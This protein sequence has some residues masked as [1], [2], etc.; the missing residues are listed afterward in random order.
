MLFR[1]AGAGEPNDVGKSDA[2]QYQ[3]SAGSTSCGQGWWI[4]RPEQK[5]LP[6]I[7]RILQGVYSVAGACRANGPGGN[8]FPA[9]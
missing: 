5:W 7:I 9:L 6:C 2:L 3:D 4:E 8:G 1:V